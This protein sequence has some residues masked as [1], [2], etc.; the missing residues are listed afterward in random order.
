VDDGDDLH[1]S[2]HQAIKER[3]REARK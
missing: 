2:V 1:L 3:I